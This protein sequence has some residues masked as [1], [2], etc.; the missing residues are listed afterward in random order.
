L[1]AILFAMLRMTA[2]L[3]LAATGGIISQQAGMINVALEGLMLIGAFAGVL[4]AYYAQSAW[5]GALAAVATGALFAGLL[6]LAVLGLRA[7]LIVAG[8]ALNL[9]VLGLTR[10]LLQI[11]FATRGAFAPER[12]PGLGTLEIPALQGFPILGDIILGHSPLVYFSWILALLSAFFLNHTPE[13][14][15]LRAVGENE[16]AARSLGVPVNRVRALALVASGCLAGLAGVQLSLGNL[17]LFFENMTNGRGFIALAAIYF[18]QARPALTLLACLLFGLFEAIQ[19][20]LQTRV[21][22]PPQW[23]QMLPFILVILVLAGVSMH[24]RA[25][26]MFF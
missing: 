23:P 19:I 15:R 6:A 8:L 14:L 17:Q 5:V 1:S 11:L 24:R 4:I 25:R 26:R 2:P 13:G 22:I 3:I 20:R 7:N 9:L 21:G 18:G 16:E 10:Y 12:L